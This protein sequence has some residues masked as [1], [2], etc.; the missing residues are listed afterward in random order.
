MASRAFLL[1]SHLRN[2][3]KDYFVITMMNANF[4]GMYVRFHNNLLSQS[5]DCHNFGAGFIC[6]LGWGFVDIWWKGGGGGGARAKDRVSR[7]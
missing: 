6:R 2:L 3:Y 4:D 1:V 5:H 7:F